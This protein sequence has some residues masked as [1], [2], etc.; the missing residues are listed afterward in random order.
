M[1]DQAEMK[2]SSTCTV[3]TFQNHPSMMQCE[4]CGADLPKEIIPTVTSSS[5]ST[6]TSNRTNS[7]ATQ[8]RLSFRQSGHSSFLSK[9]KGALAAKKWEEVVSPL[10]A[11]QPSTP[12]T[13]GVGISKWLI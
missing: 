1:A 3:C 4:M 9:L 7:N 6:S 11:S 2:D 5:S 13:R 8:V 12:V 10:P